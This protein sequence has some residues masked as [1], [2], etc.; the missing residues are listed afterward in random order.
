M[1]SARQTNLKGIRI[2]KA[3]KIK[4]PFKKISIISDDITK[5]PIKPSP[6]IHHKHVLRLS[7]P[8]KPVPD[9]RLYLWR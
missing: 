3:T 2:K 6:Q 5:I 8:L 7:R 9:L 4:N 1:E